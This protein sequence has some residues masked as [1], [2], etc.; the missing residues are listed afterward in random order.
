MKTAM[1][2][3]VAL[4][5]SG[6]ALAAPGDGTQDVPQRVYTYELDLDAG[7]AITGLEPHGFAPDATSAEL[8]QDIRGWLFRSGDGSGDGVPTRT[9]LRVVVQPQAA[10]GGDF[11][12]VSATTGPAPAQLSQPEYPVR[13][14]LAGREGMVV[15]KLRVGADG[16]VAAADV[17]ATTDKVSRSMAV[18]ASEAAQQW[19]FEP[20]QVGGQAVAATILWPVCYLGRATSVSECS[21]SGPDAQHFSSKT[22]LPLDSAATLVSQR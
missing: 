11:E 15:L 9:Y 19:R 18:A 2:L 22:V 7:G 14:Q 16:A 4:A 5:L 1:F 13:D 8:A 21:W 6:A 20:E 12:V 10:Q 3:S 17:L